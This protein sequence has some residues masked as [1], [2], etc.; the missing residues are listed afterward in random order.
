MLQVRNFVLVAIAS[1]VVHLAHYLELRLPSEVCTCSTAAC[2]C[3]PIWLSTVHGS[4]PSFISGFF[5]R[6]PFPPQHPSSYPAYREVSHE[7][8]GPV[9]HL[10]P[11]PDHASTHLR[12]REREYARA[13]PGQGPDSRRRCDRAARPPGHWRGLGP[14]GQKCPR[15]AA[16]RTRSAESAQRFE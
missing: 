16:G 5:F 12:M 7:Y 1:L 15:C 11:P 8:L 6:T 3:P 4:S 14:L 9:L 2:L 10:H 13:Q